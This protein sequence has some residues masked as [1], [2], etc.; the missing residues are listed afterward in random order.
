MSTHRYGVCAEI[1]QLLLLAALPIQTSTAVLHGGL[2]AFGSVLLT[3]QAWGQF[4]QAANAAL[5]TGNITITIAYGTQS[6]TTLTTGI[7]AASVTATLD[8]ASVPCTLS[9]TVITFTPSVAI[10]TGSTLKVVLA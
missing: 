1:A 10:P 6:L 5:T 4:T 9:G 3:G 8:T 2:Q 7:T